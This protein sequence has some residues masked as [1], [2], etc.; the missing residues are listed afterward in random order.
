MKQKEPVVI[1]DPENVGEIPFWISSNLC[2]ELLG[3][4]LV[5]SDSHDETGAMMTLDGGWYFVPCPGD[6]VIG[7]STLRAQAK[8]TT[9]PKW[10]V[11]V[12]FT[13]HNYPHSPDETDL[14]EVGVR[15]NSLDQCIES[16]AILELENKTRMIGEGLFWSAENF[17]QKFGYYKTQESW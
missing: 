10:R 4:Q 11:E 12:L 2:K 8:P 7:N 13:E 6:F 17:K 14:K 1:P 16:A 9:K 5:P 15:T 3:E